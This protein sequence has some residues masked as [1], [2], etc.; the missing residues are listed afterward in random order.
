MYVC[1]NFVC[2]CVCVCVV[3]CVALFLGQ[4]LSLA[5]MSV[6][7]VVN[8]ACVHISLMYIHGYILGV[9]LHAASGIVLQACAANY[10][11]V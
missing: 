4:L 8:R 6:C 7:G 11:G 2:V 10:G 1:V 3:P 9:C 5:Y